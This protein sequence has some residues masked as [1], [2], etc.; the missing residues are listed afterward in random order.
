M[1]YAIHAYSR[2][3]NQRQREFAQ[4]EL[5]GRPITDQVQAQRMADSFAQRLNQRQLLK[6]TDWVGEIEL[7]NNTNIHRL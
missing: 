6:A 7:V 5:Q 3:A 1:F 4:D 2:T